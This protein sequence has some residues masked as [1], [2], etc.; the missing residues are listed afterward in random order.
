MRDWHICLLCRHFLHLHWNSDVDLEAPHTLKLSPSD[1]KPQVKLS[2]LKPE[3][4]YGLVSRKLKPFL[5]I[6]F[7][8][9]FS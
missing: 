8:H 4:H 7:E 6:N 3:S 9:I 2:I 5:K 1:R